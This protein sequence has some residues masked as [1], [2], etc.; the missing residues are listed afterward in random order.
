MGDANSS[1]SGPAAGGKKDFASS[2]KMKRADLRQH[3]R[4]RIGEAKAEMYLKGFLS[5]LGLGRKNEARVAVNLSE[6]GI[7]VSTA[8]KLAPGTKVQ[9]RIEM[10]KYKDVIETEGEV[11]WCYVSARNASE[12]YTGIQFVKLPPAHLSKISQMRAWF[13]SPEFKQKSATRRRLA[14]PELTR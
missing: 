7:M 11:R 1:G 5:K 3:P 10:E 12:Y 4:F 13:T 14:D 8:T 6:G 2:S 9:L